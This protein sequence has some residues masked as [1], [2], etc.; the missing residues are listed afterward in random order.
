M[1][2][3]LLRRAA[4]VVFGLILGFAALEGL[5]QLGALAVRARGGAARLVALG[6]SNTYGLYV[7]KEN[8]YPRLLETGWNG[9]ENGRRLEVLNLGYP[10]NNSSVLRNRF[11]AVLA[12]YRP[13]AV[14]IQ[15]GVNDFWSMPEPIVADDAS[16]SVWMNLVRR[17]RTGRLLLILE[18][19]LAGRPVERLPGVEGDE[20]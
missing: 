10:G 1:I 19:S 8:A 17:S 16:E 20:R 6:D 9:Q 18:R 2:G 4:L 3:T 7:G 14:L 12:D 5:L 11:R 15:I 13:D